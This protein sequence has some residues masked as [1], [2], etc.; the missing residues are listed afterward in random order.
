MLF[1]P[2]TFTL[3]LDLKDCTAC[4]GSGL[5]STRIDCRACNGSGNGPR[6]GKGRCP[7]CHGY[8]NDYDHVNQSTCEKCNGSPHRAESENWCDN[9]PAE[10]V[11]ALQLRVA[12]QD[13]E[14][15]WNESYLGLNSLWSCQDYGTAW[16]RPDIE[17]LSDVREKLLNDRTQ[18]VKL[19]AGDYDRDATTAP[20]VRGLV[21]VV[22]RGGYSVRADT[23]LAESLA[24]REPDYTTAHIVG[25]AVYNAGGNG[26]MAA[27]MPLPEYKPNNQKEN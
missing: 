8:G 12:R 15:S 2:N 24:E 26:T 3:T 21:V 5:V 17:V 19:L 16:E 20:I 9:T 6:G 4:F 10:A 13:R 18:A 23:S 1:D 11:A 25:M 22:S 14:V 27:A 7:K